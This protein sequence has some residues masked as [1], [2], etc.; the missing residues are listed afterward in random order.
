MQELG[1]LAGGMTD[2][3]IWHEKVDLESELTGLA[4]TADETFED[5]VRQATGTM[6]ATHGF[7]GKLRRAKQRALDLCKVYDDTA[8][9]LGERAQIGS[10]EMEIAEKAKQASE[11][12][13][14]TL[15]EGR[16]LQNMARDF[17]TPK[18]GRKANVQDELDKL[19]D[20]DAHRHCL[21]HSAI[22]KKAQEFVMS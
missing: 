21:I 8:L 22:I 17:R 12:A 20:K 4:D 15:A 6:W 16:L 1:L 3:T 18:E 2:G 5:V 13:E 10:H 14:K 9:K 19:H 11:L 7:V